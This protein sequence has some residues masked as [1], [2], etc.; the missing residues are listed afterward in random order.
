[1]TSPSNIPAV[2]AL[3]LATRDVDPEYVAEIAA[4]YR[5]LADWLEAN[6]VIAT[7]TKYSDASPTAFARSAERFEEL[8][9]ELRTFSKEDN[10]VYLNAVVRDPDTN[11]KIVT[12]AVRKE[13]TCTRVQVGTETV[14]VATPVATETRIETVEQPVYE[15][16][17]PD[18][19]LN[20]TVE[21]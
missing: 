4:H 13:L 15:W 11:R 9:R 16:Q 7:A 17:C 12:V 10:D 20:R 2:D 1:M 5:A 3:D 8:L 14:E 19:W 6:P 18:S 21:R